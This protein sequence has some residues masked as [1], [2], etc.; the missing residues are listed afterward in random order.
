MS[1]GDSITIT[2]VAPINENDQRS[3]DEC[4]TSKTQIDRMA[5]DETRPLF[6]WVDVAADETCRVSDRE[7]EAY[8]TLAQAPGIWKIHTHPSR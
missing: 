4:Q 2:I 5:L 1:L 3:S 6:F 8:E 7:E